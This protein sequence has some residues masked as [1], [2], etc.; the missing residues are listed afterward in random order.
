MRSS[1]L[2]RVVI[3]GMGA[4]SPLGNSVAQ[5]WQGLSSGRSGIDLITQF[6]DQDF[7]YPIAGE[8]RGFDPRDYMD[9]KAS[10][11]MARFAQFAVAAAGE[12]LRDSGLDLAYEDRT[13]VAVDIGTGLGGAATTEEESLA[14]ARKER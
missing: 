8:V 4:I 2:Q 11:R 7:P 13:M 6:D 10:R 1:T 9:L 5:M 12:A 3:T 14:F